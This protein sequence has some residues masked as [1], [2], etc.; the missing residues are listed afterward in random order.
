M[1]FKVG[2]IQPEEGKYA[3][4]LY[5]YGEII[6]IHSVDAPIPQSEL[7]KLSKEIDGAVYDA[8]TQAILYGNDYAERYSIDKTRKVV[9]GWLEQ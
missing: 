1:D 2:M 4:A 6:D 9:N 7:D 5:L 3:L 8:V